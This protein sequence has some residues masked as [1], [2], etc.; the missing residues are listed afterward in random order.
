M[1]HFTGMSA[2]SETDEA[3]WD[4]RCMKFLLHEMIAHENFAVLLGTAKPRKY[5]ARENFL[6]IISQQINCEWH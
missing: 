1:S 6:F 4:F 3:G 5:H 2:A